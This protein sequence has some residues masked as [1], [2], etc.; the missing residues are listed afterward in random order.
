MDI[1]IFV[2]IIHEA[3]SECISLNVQPSKAVYEVKSEIQKEEEIPPINQ[4]LVFMG[5]EL[6]NDERLSFYNIGNKAIL[7]IDA[8]AME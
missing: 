4:C 8:H 7:S 3:G 1:E 2:Q 5:K 6:E